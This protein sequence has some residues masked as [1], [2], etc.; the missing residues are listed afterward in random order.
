MEKGLKVR[1]LLTLALAVS[2][3][4]AVF[5][6]LMAKKLVIGYASKSSTAPFWGIVQKGVDQAAK[7]L[8][9][10]VITLGP[11][12]ENDIAG[13]L[14]VIEDLIN[15]KVDA[16]AIAPC[17]SVGVGPAV[18]KANAKKIP[19]VALDTPISEGKTVT[20]VATDNIK[21]A[22]SAAEW[23]GKKLNGK[24]NVVLINGMIAQG[25]G[26]ERY[27]GFRDYAAKKY[28]G[29]KIVAAI[30]ADWNEDKALKGMEDAIKANPQIDGV[31][32]GWDGAALMAYRALTE[33]K[34]K[35]KTAICGFDCYPQSLK[36]MKQGTFEADV[37]QYPYKIGYEAIKAA[38]MA[39]KGEKVNPRIDTGTMLVLPDNV[40]QYIKDNNVTLPD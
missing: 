23:M 6:P 37:S 11:P 27:E 19:V 13:Q 20:F 16:L 40:D 24:G 15:R 31:F 14:N 18:K 33:A 22:E 32:V 21:A 28:P 26:K 38:V 25:T 4:L 39:A 36:L 5:S 35:D 34:R 9:V 17:D 30:P 7:D 8:D 12:K 3:M 1:G 10:T 29:I 2:F